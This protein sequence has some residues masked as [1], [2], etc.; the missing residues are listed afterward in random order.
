MT[1]EGTCRR[2]ILIGLAAACALGLVGSFTPHASSQITY[3]EPGSQQPECQPQT[4][5]VT[6]CHRSEGEKL[7]RVVGVGESCGEHETGVTFGRG[8]Q[9][10]PGSPGEPGPPGPAGAAGRPGISAIETITRL[11]AG[12]STD[13]KSIGATCPSGKRVVSG[14]ARIE[15]LSGDLPPVAVQQSEPAQ[16]GSAWLVVA[17]EVRPY[18]NSWRVYAIALCAVVS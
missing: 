10:T 17:A 13:A 2:K 7:V 1:K 6:A 5:S 3:C 4:A 11:S 16:N 8:E 14:G 15:D 12:G 18:A 9:G